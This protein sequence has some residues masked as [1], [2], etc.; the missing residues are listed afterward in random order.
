MF[1][2]MNAAK[3]HGSTKGCPESRQHCSHHHQPHVPHQTPS[4][5]KAHLHPP[6]DS[7]TTQKRLKIYFRTITQTYSN[8][9]SR[10]LRACKAASTAPRSTQESVRQQLTPHCT[11]DNDAAIMLLKNKQHHLQIPL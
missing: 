3:K 7:T 10:H 2:C 11:T 6:K 5:Q 8:A 4:T 9:F 1:A